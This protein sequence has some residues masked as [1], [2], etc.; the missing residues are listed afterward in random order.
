MA[1]DLHLLLYDPRPDILGTGVAAAFVL[2]VAID[3]VRD[4]KSLTLGADQPRI[5]Q[6]HFKHGPDRVCDRERPKGVQ[7]LL[8]NSQAG[9]GRIVK[10]EQEEGFRNHVPSF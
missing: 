5:N 4:L 1:L 7:I 8:S 10:Q 2:E 9:P 6:N 3:G